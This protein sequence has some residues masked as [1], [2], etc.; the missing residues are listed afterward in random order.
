[1]P[2]CPQIVNTPIPVVN[3]ADF[4]VTSVQPVIPATSTELDAAIAIA[5]AALAEAALAFDLA[6]NSLQES[7]NTIT[8]ASNQ[9]TAMNTNGITVYSGSSATTGARVIMNSAGLTGFNSAGTSTFAINAANGNV[10]MTGALFTGG[11]IFGGT[12]N[13][14]GNAIIDA[15]GFLTATGATVTGR[16]VATSGNIGGFTITANDYLTYGT[17]R[18]W[19]GSSSAPINAGVYDCITDTSRNALFYGLTTFGFLNTVGTITTNGK[20]T[21]GGEVEAI[22]ELRATF[23]AANSVTSTPNAWMSTTGQIRRST[24]SSIRYK[25]DIVNLVD[26]DELHP[27]KLL[28]IPVRAFRYKQEFLS[29][30]DDRSEIL[31]PGFIAEEVDSTYPMA[32]DYENGEPESWND[33][34]LVPGMLALIQDLYKEIALLKGE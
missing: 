33:R 6:E 26:V 20:I 4:V 21:G 31:M 1:M 34:I 17:M 7:V 15:S 23:G 22:G 10:S 8:N 24:A 2:L 18:I 27:K 29:D 32:T 19:G 5:E 30:T 14:N 3:S 16:I 25:E 12:L 28:N 13:I 11:T 9:I